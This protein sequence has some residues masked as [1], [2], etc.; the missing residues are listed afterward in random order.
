MRQGEKKEKYRHIVRDFLGIALMLIQG[1]IF[2]YVWIHYFNPYIRMPYRFKGNYFL[3]GVYVVL[4]LVF[5]K[6]YGGMK[7]GYYRVFD[8]ILSQSICTFITNFVTYF[9]IVIPVATWYLSPEPLIW[10]TAVNILVVILW[11]IAS[12]KIF[13]HLFP[14]QRL[15]MLYTNDSE[16]LSEKFAGRPDR[17]LVEKKI[18]LD[19]NKSN[20]L[21]KD[22][23]DIINQCEK[24]DGVIIGDI[25][26]DLRNDLLKRCYSKGIRTYTLP[27]VSDVILK[28]SEILHIFDSTVLLNRNYGL[29]AEQ[30]LAKRIFD[31]FLSGLGIVISSPILCLTAIAI[32]IEDGGPVFFRQKRCTKNGHV[33]EIIKFRSMIVNAEKEG[34]FI[35][36]TEKDP[37]IT[38]VGSFIRMTR[39]DEL[40]QL[41]NILKGDMSIVGPRPERIEHVEKYTA[42]I[43]EFGYRLMVKGGLT[44]YAQIYGK[45]NT[46]AYDKLKLD[47]MYIQN[48]SLL[49]DI[50]L[51]L[52]TVKVV[53]TKESTE[54]FD[55]KKHNGNAPKTK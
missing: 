53:F 49:M 43:P 12:N 42:E 44:G 41:F 21:K 10:M 47:L 28:S 32:K 16:L 14:P 39:I 30:E 33:F 29:T 4:T 7:I 52:K 35:P 11:S 9:A 51:I 23:D 5:S 46:S 22:M 8:I 48:Y 15:L 34:E 17:Y 50:S 25:K 37:R 18:D 31:L 40:P 1:F 24:Y 45:Y 38:R 27:K 6:V 54:G 2:L 55:A 13:I 26:A 19:F 3:M 20:Y 36:A